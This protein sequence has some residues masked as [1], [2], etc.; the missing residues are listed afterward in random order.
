[1]NFY[2]TRKLILSVFGIIAI[3]VA[4]Y[5][6]GINGFKFETAGFPKVV[7]DRTI[8]EK[9]KSVD[10][11]LF[12]KVWDTLD[13]SYFDKTKLIPSQMVYGAISGMVNSIGDPYT[14]FLTPEENKV[15]DRKSV[16]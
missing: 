6:L 15:V 12:W 9:H 8:P 2:K 13:S 10:F 11:S 14:S 4:G 1:M 5:V 7:I 16:V 3:F